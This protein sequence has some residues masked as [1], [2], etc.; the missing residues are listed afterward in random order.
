[1]DLK[2]EVLH[3]IHW[4]TFNLA[5]HSWYEP[6]VR[7]TAAASSRNIKIVTSA[8]SETTVYGKPIPAVRWWEQAMQ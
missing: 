5:L 7:L 2:G 6:M 1:M 4:G 8:V 3:P